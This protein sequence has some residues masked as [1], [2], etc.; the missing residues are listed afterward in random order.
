MFGDKEIKQQDVRNGKYWRKVTTWL[1]ILI[2]LKLFE[3]ELLQR[4]NLNF[5]FYLIM[6]GFRK[7]T[8]NPKYVCRLVFPVSQISDRGHVITFTVLE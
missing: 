4:Q 6:R 2:E 8:Q 3:G 1:M 7:F 5:A